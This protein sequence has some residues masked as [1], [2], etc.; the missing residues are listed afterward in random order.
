MPLK[1]LCMEK[2]T[3]ICATQGHTFPPHAHFKD[4]GGHH[5]HV[6]TTPR[7]PQVHDCRWKDNNPHWTVG[8]QTGARFC[9]YKC[10]VELIV[11]G[12]VM[13]EQPWLRHLSGGLGPVD[14]L[15]HQ[16][17]VPPSLF[18]CK[19]LHTLVITPPV[20]YFWVLNIFSQCYFVVKSA[21]GLS[22]CVWKTANR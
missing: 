2:W 11:M 9:L 18:S 6:S 12:S 13:P 16:W 1:S 14:I 8:V 4:C 15:S 17:D 5:V 19:S 20:S 22:Q 3:C 7:R 21:L 10:C